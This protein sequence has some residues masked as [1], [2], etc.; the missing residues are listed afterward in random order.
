VASPPTGREGPRPPIGGGLARASLGAATADRGPWRG[1][2]EWGRRAADL[3]AA[4]AVDSRQ[5]AIRVSGQD[6]MVHAAACPHPERL[7]ALCAAKPSQGAC[8]AVGLC[9]WAAAKKA[10]RQCRGRACRRANPN[11]L[12]QDALV[13]SRRG[14]SSLAWRRRRKKKRSA[15]GTE[16]TFSR[17]GFFVL[18]LGAPS[19]A[20]DATQPLAASR[21]EMT[22]GTPAVVC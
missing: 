9:R 21:E 19:S 5:P 1:R 3:R 6:K 17:A 20:R 12:G 7:A 14:S 18:A 2:R 4:C 16:A 10:G 22:S 15:V 13:A 11:L 8:E